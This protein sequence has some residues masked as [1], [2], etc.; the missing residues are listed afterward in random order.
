MAA[1][2]NFQ[3]YKFFKCIF[4]FLLLLMVLPIWIKYPNMKSFITDWAYTDV[5]H[6]ER[7]FYIC[8]LFMGR[9]GN[10]MFQYA[11]A[12]GISTEKD[13]RVIIPSVSLIAKTFIVDADMPENATRV[14]STFPVLYEPHNAWGI[15]IQSFSFGIY[16]NSS[17]CMRGYFQSYKYFN[18]AKN[19]IKQQF[20]SFKEETRIKAATILQEARR[21]YLANLNATNVTLIGVHVRRGDKLAG[22]ETLLGQTIA[23]RE[24]FVKAMDYFNSKYNNSV[25]IICG[26]N[27]TW[28]KENIQPTYSV[29]FLNQSSTPDVDLAIL[30]MC[31]HMIMSI[32]SYS[33]WAAYLNAGEVIYYKD[34]II[35]GSY[36]SKGFK[37]D[38]YFPPQWI[39]K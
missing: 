5:K 39:P 30:A 1:T 6:R 31:D 27:Q 35:P 11:T 20:M 26:E 3:K 4:S 24:Y 2:I 21:Y 32:G 22:A 13:L 8:P 16:G 18:H 14:C 34:W 23:P 25:F 17:V 37:H 19:A 36:V 15:H 7:T 9:L 38:D 29:I 10:T 28:A 12:Y 33:W